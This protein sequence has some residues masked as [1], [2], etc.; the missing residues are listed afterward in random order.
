[1]NAKEKSEKKIV[2]LFSGGLD[3]STMLAQAVKE[4]EKGAEVIAISFLYGQ[5]HRKELKSAKAISDFY[6]VENKL[7][8]VPQLEG[9][10]LTSE[11]EVVKS[12]NDSLPS[13]FVP[14]RN[15]LFLTLGA[16]QGFMRSTREE[17]LEIWIGAT[18]A[19]Q[20]GYPDCRVAFLQKMEEALKE[21]LDRPL[22]KV[23]SPLV[24]LSKKEIVLEAVKI[25]VPLELTWTCYEGG[26][27]PCG[28]CAS[29]LFREEGFKE[30]GV[31]DPIK[32]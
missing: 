26:E 10:S 3:S 13:T 17:N 9:S 27:K 15:I 24:K 6:K 2:V 5:K 32:D 25:G 29:C 4:R 1:M 21:G 19:D 14:G 22:I 11:G 18:A 30:A 23:K 28:K 31:K 7:V 8:Q 20:E 12:E 16:A